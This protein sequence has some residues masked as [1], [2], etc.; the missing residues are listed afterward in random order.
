[1]RYCLQ[2]KRQK[3]KGKRNGLSDFFLLPFA[4]CLLPFRWTS[5]KSVPLVRLA[6]AAFLVLSGWIIAGPFTVG[7]ADQDPGKPA[8]PQGKVQPG[9]NKPSNRK[10]KEEEEEPSKP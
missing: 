10:P 7:G 3:A 5:G 9:K 2:G 4:F 6:A 1:M 8:A